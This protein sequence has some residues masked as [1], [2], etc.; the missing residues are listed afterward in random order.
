MNG[1]FTLLT[2]VWLTIKNLYFYIIKEEGYRGKFVRGFN[3]RIPV[4]DI[5]DA[6]CNQSCI[7]A[8]NIS[9]CDISLKAIANEEYFRI[10]CFKFSFN[11]IEHEFGR[12]AEME[13]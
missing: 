6:C 11:F 7:N 12:F 10:F 1:Y 4:P 5:F 2:E 13:F 8:E 3:I 9:H